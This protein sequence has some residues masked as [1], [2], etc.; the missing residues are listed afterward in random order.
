M[1]LKLRFPDTTEIV[2]ITGSD[3]TDS[4]ITLQDLIDKFPQKL[5]SASIKTG[6][7]PKL[8]N[9]SDP[10]ATLFTLGIKNGEQ[11]V[12]ELKSFEKP[13]NPAVEPVT[14]ANKLEEKLNQGSL[15]SGGRKSSPVLTKKLASQNDTA[16]SGSRVSKPSAPIKTKF[17]SQ[18]QKTQVPESSIPNVSDDLIQVKCGSYG[19]LRLRVM[20]DDN[21]CLFRAVGYTVLKDLDS[22]FALRDAV[23]NA[24]LNNPDVYSDAI[25]GKKREIYMSWI[26]QENSWGGAIELEILAKHFGLTICSLDIS[27]LRQDMFNP[28]QDRFVIIAYSGIHYDAVALSKTE[29]DSGRPEDDQTIF[30]GDMKGMEV[31]EALGELGKKLKNKHYYTDTAKFSIRCNACGTPLTGEKEAT[32][33]AMATGHTDFGEY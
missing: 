6:F 1:R 28:G 11:L 15:A 2:T 14:E 9:T 22:M 20:E 19:Y 24:I 16:L 3:E 26:C 8:V 18:V 12:I 29:F 30:E 21:S 27:T 23:R 4:S 32:K 31:L 33:H 5:G 25:L 7:P 13:Q 17:T 10:T